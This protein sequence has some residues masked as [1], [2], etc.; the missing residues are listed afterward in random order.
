MSKNPNFLYLIPINQRIKILVQNSCL[1]YFIDPQSHAKIQKK[2]ISE[3]FKAGLTIDGQGR[4][5]RTL[6]RKP[7]VQNNLCHK[8]IFRQKITKQDQVNNGPPD[9]D[10]MK[11]NIICFKKGQK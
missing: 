8:I 2:P 11:T 6:S 5:L 7:R 10:L 9:I 1:F 3:L 4:L